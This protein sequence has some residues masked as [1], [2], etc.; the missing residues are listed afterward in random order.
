MVRLKKL[1]RKEITVKVGYF[2][3]S[4]MRLKAGKGFLCH[5]CLLAISIPV[6]CD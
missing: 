5:V 4:M 2:N 1:F 3:S 6:W